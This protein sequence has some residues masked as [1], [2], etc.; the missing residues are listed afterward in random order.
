M[1]VYAVF[2]QAV[3]RHECCGIFTTEP[4]AEACALSV[5]EHEDGHHE[6]HVVPFDLD[7]PGALVP[8][9]DDGWPMAE[10]LEPSSSVIYRREKS[11]GRPPQPVER[12][13][14]P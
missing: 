9:G 11:W 5:A 12:V 13:V 1:K 6:V 10:V 4:L 7:A 3:Y 2:K 14:R 8:A